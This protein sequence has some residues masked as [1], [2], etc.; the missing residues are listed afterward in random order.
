MQSLSCSYDK[1][2]NTSVV[3]LPH[4][5]LSVCVLK[6]LGWEVNWKTSRREELLWRQL[7]RI[8]NQMSPGPNNQVIIH[9]LCVPNGI[10]GP[11]NQDDRLCLL[12]MLQSHHLINKAPCFFIQH[13]LCLLHWIPKQLL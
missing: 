6:S 7:L 13:H 4:V 10:S 9:M 5:R 2:S 12:I 3:C 1:E 11:I 8:T